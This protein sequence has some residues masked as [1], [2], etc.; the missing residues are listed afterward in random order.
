MELERA[1]ALKERELRK[2]RNSRQ[3]AEEALA[4]GAQNSENSECVVL[5]LKEGVGKGQPPEE[6]S[7]LHQVVRP[8]LGDTPRSQVGVPSPHCSTQLHRGRPEGSMPKA[9]TP[10][11]STPRGGSK[12]STPLGST[13]RG[14]TP[15][16]SQARVMQLAERD[17][18]SQC[19]SLSVYVA[20]G[21][22]VLA[23]AALFGWVRSRHARSSLSL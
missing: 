15:R 4:D 7:R 1:L 9:S 14:S 12:G 17:K 5:S 2:E 16:G 18:L 13:P 10:R 6:S 3:Y 22:A 21:T 20:A 19:T 8:M 23:C 11:G